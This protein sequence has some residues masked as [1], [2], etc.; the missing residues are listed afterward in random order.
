[1]KNRLLRF[2]KHE[3]WKARKNKLPLTFVFPFPADKPPLPRPPRT[4][5]K[6]MQSYSF[7]IQIDR[8][9]NWLCGH[10]RKI[11]VGIVRCWE[12][13][14]NTTVIT[15][16]VTG[17]QHQQTTTAH[18]AKVFFFFSQYISALQSVKENNPWNCAKIN[19]HKVW[20]FNISLRINLK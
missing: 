14:P 3:Y 7:C 16:P 19:H 11:D 5:P 20:Y 17:P 13:E 1:M 2:D 8:Y 15:R 10:D 18:C 4:Q 9:T 6:S 12:T